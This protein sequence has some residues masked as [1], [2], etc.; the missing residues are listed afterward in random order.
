MNKN[1]ITKDRIIFSVIAS[2]LML[3]TGFPIDLLLFAGVEGQ[4]GNPP[5][6]KDIHV[7]D[8]DIKKI[9]D[10]YWGYS[11]KTDVYKV[12]FPNKINGN[13]IKITTLEEKYQLT[14]KP[15]NVKCYDFTGNDKSNIFSTAKKVGPT[16]NR[17]T[18][19]YP[20]VYDNVDLR[21]E[22]FF[23]DCKETFIIKKMPKG[24]NSTLMFQN[25]INF[26]ISK[27]SVYTNGK[28]INETYYGS[29]HDS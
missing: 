12:M 7:W 14:M 10:N 25:E 20:N 28:R 22:I 21:Y 5:P 19:T 18:I 17:T 26:D 1:F 15:V 2:V 29:G 27:L 24:V 11:A 13:S 16:V 9:K 8:F 3:L 6:G 4:G 23:H